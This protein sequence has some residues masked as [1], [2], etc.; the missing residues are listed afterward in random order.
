MSSACSN[1]RLFS[2]LL[3]LLAKLP[4]GAGPR[5]E[6]VNA[7][8]TIRDQPWTLLLPTISPDFLWCN[9]LLTE[10]FGWSPWGSCVALRPMFL[11][12]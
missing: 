4:D 11:F 9:D 12:L 8:R 1:P 6:R 2:V 5:R 10:K 7:P 3:V